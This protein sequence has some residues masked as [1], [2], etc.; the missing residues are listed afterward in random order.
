MRGT[1]CHRVGNALNDHSHAVFRRFK[2][3]KA[4]GT[5]VTFA[6]AASKC[7]ITVIL[8]GRLTSRS[9]IPAISQLP[10]KSVRTRRSKE[11]SDSTGGRENARQ[12]PPANFRETSGM[13][14]SSNRRDVPRRRDREGFVNS[15]SISMCFSLLSYRNFYS[16]IS[17]FFFFCILFFKN[18]IKKKLRFKVYS[19]IN[20]NWTCDTKNKVSFKKLLLCS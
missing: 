18:L 3:R 2:G 13:N 20:T 5:R 1:R 15:Y 16:M 17:F 7:P 12:L 14:D 19:R 6:R 4:A 9:L 8:S 11:A 10:I